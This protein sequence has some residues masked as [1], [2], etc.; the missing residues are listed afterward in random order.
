MWHLILLFTSKNWNISYERQGG[1]I[2]CIFRSFYNLPYWTFESDGWTDGRTEERTAPFRNATTSREDR[3]IKV[4][5]RKF[6]KTVNDVDFRKWN[7][8]L[9]EAAITTTSRL[10]LDRHTNAMLRPLD[11]TIAYLPVLAIV[12]PVLYYLPALAAVPW[13]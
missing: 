10:R 4:N 11:V 3:I 2:S 9:R 1:N 13:H 5:A 6:L 7:S 12:L 8:C